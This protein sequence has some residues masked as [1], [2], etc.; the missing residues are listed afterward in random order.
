M[1]FKRFLVLILL[2]LILTTTISPVA[3]KVVISDRTILLASRGLHG[4][5]GVLGDEKSTRSSTIIERGKQFYDRGNLTEAA[6]IWES[7]AKIFEKK[8]IIPK[9]TIYGNKQKCPKCSHFL[10]NVI[11]SVAPNK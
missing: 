9:K 7:A 2:T 8:C 3:A 4:R 1:N 10:I 6:Q 5:D 11:S